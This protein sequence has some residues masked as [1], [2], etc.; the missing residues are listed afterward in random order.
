MPTTAA[1]ATTLSRFQQIEAAQATYLDDAELQHLRTAPG[2]ALRVTAPFG[3]AAWYKHGKLLI[4]AAA[5]HLIDELL[6]DAHG[7]ENS[8]HGGERELEKRTAAYYWKNKSA[9]IKIKIARCIDCQLKLAPPRPSPLGELHINNPSGANQLVIVDHVP[10]KPVSQRGNT[11]ILSFTDAFTRETSVYAVRSLSADDALECLKLFIRKRAVPRTIQV[12]GSLS[13]AG[14]FDDFCKANNIGLHGIPA[15]HQQANGKGERPHGPLL[16]KLRALAPGGLGDLWDDALPI[17]E[18]AVF[19]SF[20]RILKMS[21]FELTFGRPPVSLLDRQSGADVDAPS[22]H[23]PESWRDMIQTMHETIDMLNSSA[24]IIQREAVAASH[25]QAFSFKKG[26]SVMLIRGKSRDFKMQASVW[27]PGYVVLDASH[28]DFYTVAR[29]EL[30]DTLSAHEY[31][32]A[33]RLRPSDTSAPH[34]GAERDV[35]VGHFVVKQIMSHEVTPSG[36]VIFT[37]RWSDDTISSDYTLQSL[38]L[39]CRVMLK[40]YCAAN[41][42]SWY[43]LERQRAVENKSGKGAK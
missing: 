6:D 19:T 7:L 37:L 3:T 42:I 41:E 13:F 28:P 31:V 22:G 15:H 17:A 25:E 26:D 16:A 10:M 2:Y 12:D 29:R 20:H 32:P 9:D 8:V 11:A 39:G 38:M 23:T 5:T 35:K 36:S 43:R 4:P 34:G 24:S 1:R 14:S 30:D 21:S 40:A 27:Q 18:F 33:S